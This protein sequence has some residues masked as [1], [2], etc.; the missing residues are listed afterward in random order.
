MS[1]KLN[2]HFSIYLLMLISMIFSLNSNVLAYSIA[3]DEVLSESQ[4]ELS[5]VAFNKITPANGATVD[6]PANSYYFLTWTDALAGSSDRYQYCFDKTDN[7]ACDAGNWVTRDSLYSGGPGDIQLEYGKTYYWQVRL[8]DGGL[9]ADAGDWWSFTTSAYVGPIFNK[10]NPAN[11]TVFATMPSTYHLL[12]WSDLSIS[13]T[14]RYI[15][16][17]DTSNN[18]NC[19]STWFERSNLYSGTGEFSLAYGKTYYWQVKVRDAGTQ[20]DGG[21]WHSFTISAG[22]APVLNKTFPANGATYNL[23]PS[24]YHLLQ[25]SDLFISETDRY[26]YCVDTSNNNTCNSTWFERQNLYSGTGEFPIE[27]GKTYYWQVKARDNGTVADGGTWYSFT[28]DPFYPSPYVSSIVRA[29]ADDP[30]PSASVD[31]TVTFSQSVTGVDAGD[32]VLTTTG[33]V[34]GTSITNVSGSGTTW[35]VTVDSGTENGTLRLDLIDNDT[36]KNSQSS[37]LGGVGAGNGNF[38]SGQV[39]TATTRP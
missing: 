21:T 12:Q 31:F 4:S 36:I 3:D 24:T 1:K 6:V 34:I 9:S 14:D 28:V 30:A 19:D 17:V 2:K 23:L 11:G 15:Y 7:D 20:A 37:Y 16:C 26:M 32:F 13:D 39:Y 33:A 22:G 29:S 25:W 38:T 18:N 27:Y 8:R 35:T 5:L 10:T